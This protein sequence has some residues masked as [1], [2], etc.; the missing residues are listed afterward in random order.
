MKLFKKIV[1]LAAILVCLHQ[2]ELSA[3]PY[4]HSGGIRA[5]YSSGF[6]Y[7]GFLLHRMSAFEVDFM[8]NRNGL[9]LSALYEYHL[10]PFHKSSRTFIYL[11]GGVLG[12]DWDK[13]FFMGLAAVTG[14]EYNLRDQPLN[15]SIDWRPM[16]NLFAVTEPDS[17]DWL[18]FGL[19][20][21]Y[22]FGR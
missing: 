8:Y 13:A 22:R 16:L 14:I 21:R 18:D 2:V 20:I 6:C 1:F 3:Q 15:F 7:K 17:Y 9:N 4:K 5:G 12:G 10:E 11:G 19:S